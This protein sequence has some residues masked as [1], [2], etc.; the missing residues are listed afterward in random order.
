TYHPAYLLRNLTDK[1]KAWEDLLFALLATT[2][3]ATNH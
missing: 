1:A 3:F 2:E